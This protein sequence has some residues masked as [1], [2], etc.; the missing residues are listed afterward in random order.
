[1]RARRA[2]ALMQ[3]GRRTDAGME[4]RAGMAAAETDLQRRLWTTLAVDL[5][6]QAGAARRTPPVRPGRLSDAQAGPRRRLHPGQ[7]PWS[8]PWCARRASS[9]P[10]RSR[11]WAHRPDAADADVGRPG[12]PATTS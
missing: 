7:G 5:S 10:R 2:V 11:P 1:M 12:P 4:L 6:G 8:T 3:I 9:I